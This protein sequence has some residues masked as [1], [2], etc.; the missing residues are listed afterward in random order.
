M[1]KFEELE[2]FR[3]E[4][5]STLSGS[6]QASDS[7]PQGAEHPGGGGGGGGGGGEDEVTS[8][9]EAEL[10][11]LFRRTSS[12]TVEAALRDDLHQFHGDEPSFVEHDDD[13]DMSEEGAGGDAGGRDRGRN[14]DEEEEEEEEETDE[15]MEEGEGDFDYRNG[16]DDHGGAGDEGEWEE[17]DHGQPNSESG[18]V[19]TSGASTNGEDNRSTS[20]A[21]Q[22]GEEER[23]PGKRSR[24]RPRKGK[25]QF[26]RTC[27]GHCF[28][29][30]LSVTRSR[31]KSGGGLAA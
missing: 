19:A 14:E 21:V 17:E 29:D 3:L 4:S 27:L 31:S 12:F 28:Q 8:M 6:A 20:P 11:E 1:K 25:S 13:C 18:S 2:K 26:R 22:G 30:L 16:G 9:T 10:K 15:E 23:I 5:S 7:G 24:G